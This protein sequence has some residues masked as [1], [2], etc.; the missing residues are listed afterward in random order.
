MKRFLF[1]A[2]FCAYFLTA[3]TSSETTSPAEETPTVNVDTAATV[4]ANPTGAKT[5]QTAPK[6]GNS[7]KGAS[8]STNGTSNN[9]TSPATATEPKDKIRGGAEDGN[10]AT[11]RGNAT[12]VN[13]TT[14]KAETNV[15][16]QKKRDNA[17]KVN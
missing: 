8:T 7:G 9:A 5:D 4:P 13:E 3:C 15:Q 10:S 11:V 16:E 6:S 17:K 2:A 12:I 14:G 1:L